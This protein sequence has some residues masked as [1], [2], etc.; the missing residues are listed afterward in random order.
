MVESR[1]SVFSPASEPFEAQAF[2]P[3]AQA[4]VP[5]LVIDLSLSLRLSFVAFCHGLPGSMAV[6]SMFELCRHLMVAR[7]T[8]SGLLSERRN[9]DA[10]YRIHKS[11]MVERWLQRNGKFPLLFPPVYHPWVNVI[12]RLWNAMHDTVT[13]NHGCR[14][15]DERYQLVAQLLDIVPPFPG[16]RHGVAHLR[17]AICAPRGA[18]YL[19]GGSPA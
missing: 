17:S 13:R 18:C 12:E 1:C 5:E 6:V 2:V 8:N 7:E 9:R 11:Q 14:S 10:S 16:N 3:E 4:F 15:M 19:A